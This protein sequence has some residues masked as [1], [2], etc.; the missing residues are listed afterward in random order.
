MPDNNI[1][2]NRKRIKK[3]DK[4]LDQSRTIY[5]RICYVEKKCPRTC[6]YAQK[7]DAGERMKFGW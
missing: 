2:K 4:C 7:R 3:E 5:Y 6:E 1:I